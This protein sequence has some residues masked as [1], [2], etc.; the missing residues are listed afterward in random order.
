MTSPVPGTV[1]AAVGAR[2][3]IVI[4]HA[5]PADE[6]ALRRLAQLADRRVPDGPLLVA[7]SDGALIAAAPVGGGPAISDPFRVSLDVVELLELRSQQLRVA[8]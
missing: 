5:G 1:S 7:E 2:R 4:R 8:A 6:P 3:E